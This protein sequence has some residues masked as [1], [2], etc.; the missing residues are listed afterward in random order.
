MANSDVEMGW[1]PFPGTGIETQ[2]TDKRL[3]QNARMII[4]NRPHTQKSRIKRGEI[5]N[6]P[7]PERTTGDARAHPIFI[8]Y[9]F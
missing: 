6:N 4:F 7:L 2:T 3:A 9:E 1:R 5:E 8:L